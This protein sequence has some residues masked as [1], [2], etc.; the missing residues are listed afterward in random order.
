MKLVPIVA[1]LRLRRVACFSVPVE[2]RDR[3]NL[4]RQKA[5]RLAQDHA[6]T[7]GAKALSGNRPKVSAPLFWLFDMTFEAPLEEKAGALVMVD[8]LDGHIWTD[9]EYEEYMYDYNNI[10]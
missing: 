3:P 1:D 6:R 8:R 7:V 9:D 4:D 2:Y 5:F 10:F